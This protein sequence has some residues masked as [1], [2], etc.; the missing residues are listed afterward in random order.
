MVVPSSPLR[1][2]ERPPEVS[3]KMAAFAA[4]PML[5]NSFPPMATL[6]R[7]SLDLQVRLV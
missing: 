2:I 1:T 3:I 6:G 7:I 5:Q 4:E